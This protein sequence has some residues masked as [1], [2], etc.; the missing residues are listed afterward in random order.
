MVN[1]KNSFYVILLPKGPTNN[2]ISPSI[3]FS[4][5]FL[6]DSSYSSFIA[7]YCTESTS[8]F[9]VLQLV[10]LSLQTS[11]ITSW[12]TFW[13]SL[14]DTSEHIVGFSYTNTNSIDSLRIY[15]DFP[16]SLSAFIAL[17]LSLSLLYLLTSLLSVGEAP[18]CLAQSLLQGSLHS[19]YHHHW[20]RFSASWKHSSGRPAGIPHRDLL[21][22]THTHTRCAQNVTCR[23]IDA[24]YIIFT[25]FIYSSLSVRLSIGFFFLSPERISAWWIIYCR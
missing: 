15:C 21:S 6:M 7:A 1:Q 11:Y 4:L 12:H 13:L 10:M 20:L 3:H 25:L 18:V 8:P 24:G 16:P 22:R 14:S 2:K 17:L 5:V 9:L 23:E 19:I